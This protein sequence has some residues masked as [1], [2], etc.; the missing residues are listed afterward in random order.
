MGLRGRGARACTVERSEWMAASLPTAAWF[1]ASSTSM[2]KR[3]ARAPP[4]PPLT[5][6]GALA[7]THLHNQARPSTDMQYGGMTVAMSAAHSKSQR[8]RR[9][10]AGER[11]PPDLGGVLAD[12]R[13]EDDRVNV[14]QLHEVRAQVAPQPVHIHLPG[15]HATKLASTLS[16]TA[17]V[18]A[19]PRL[20]CPAACMY[21][22][23]QQLACTPLPS[24]L[25]ALKYVK[26][27]KV[28]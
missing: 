20:P 2:P 28:T 3:C 14:P 5:I 6:T 19:R 11:E 24:S 13:A 17:P 18:H 7:P 12:A 8:G 15:T 25:H 23:A 21:S 10:H 1:R 26:A 27:C 22:L 16:G 9:L 4:P